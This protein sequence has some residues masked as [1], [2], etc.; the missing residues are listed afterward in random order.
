M[1]LSQDIKNF[2]IKDYQGK[3]LAKYY[4]KDPYVARMILKK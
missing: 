3:G 1:T 4:S 2:E